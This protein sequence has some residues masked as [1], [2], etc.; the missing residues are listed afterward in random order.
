MQAVIF[1]VL[2]GLGIWVLVR[3]IISPPQPSKKN[4]FRARF[5]ISRTS[6]SSLK[7]QN[8]WIIAGKAIGAIAAGLLIGYATGWVGAGILA[9]MLGWYGPQ[10]VFGIYSRRKNL[11]KIESVAVWA[12]Q[13]RDLV[14]AGGSVS[15][16][17]LL[18]AP[19]SPEPIRDLIQKLSQETLAFG[20]PDALRRFAVRAQSPYIDRLSLGLKIAD[21]SGA[22]LRELLDDLAEALRASV[23]VRFRVEATQTRTLLN[24]GII[25]GITLVLGIAIAALTPDYF[26][27]YYGLVG[28]IVL[29][30]V[31]F[32]YG[33]AIF[34]ILQSDKASE[35]ARLLDHIKLEEERASSQLVR[36]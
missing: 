13:L 3:G 36:T 26:D 18:S 27:E 30:G 2:L 35:G 32:L 6:L 19:Y 28:Q 5:V 33:L 7:N 24:G 11:S 22:K 16:S 15:G 25:M 12:E 4:Q 31:V 20:L 23:E 17:I 34:S 29:C 21:E 1:G 10:I 8:F 9:S 14:T